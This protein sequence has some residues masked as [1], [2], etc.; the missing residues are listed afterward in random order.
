MIKAPFGAERAMVWVLEM[1]TD[2]E[3]ISGALVGDSNSRDILEDSEV[4]PRRVRYS[5]LRM[6]HGTFE[7]E[8]AT[9]SF[10][11]QQKADS[12]AMGKVSGA[13]NK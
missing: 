11:S 6:S 1:A 5:S 3:G 7:G 9:S 2:E 12:P 13:C 8:K 10:K 4:L